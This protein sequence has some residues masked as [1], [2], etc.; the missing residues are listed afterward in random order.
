M[1]VFSCINTERKINALQSFLNT[2]EHY[3]QEEI[4]D[5]FL[6]QFGEGRSFMYGIENDFGIVV[7]DVITEISE[8]MDKIFSVGFFLCFACCLAFA[9]YAFSDE[10]QK[11]GGSFI[12]ALPYGKSYVLA[13][14]WLAGFA[15]I[16]LCMAVSFA[17]TMGFSFIFLDKAVQCQRLLGTTQNLY[18]AEKL[19]RYILAFTA[20][21]AFYSVV[22]FVFTLF[23][24]VYQAL[25]LSI[26]GV[27]AALC[28]MEGVTSFYDIYDI[29]FARDFLM[30]I[31]DVIVDL[32]VFGCTIVCI[33]AT[34]VFFALGALTN[35]LNRVENNGK[36]FMFKPVKYLAYAAFMLM[37]AFTFFE[38][39][40]SAGGMYYAIK[41]SMALGLCMLLVGAAATLWVLNKL[42]EKIG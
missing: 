41:G 34:F 33:I 32:D 38:L 2:N 26:A 5:K 17:C 15:V 29:V 7:P 37:G 25:A 13:S 22:M 4:N 16:L 9:V 36:M 39:I 35:R 12:N 14:K 24:K 11:S 42:L 27:I 30:K 40:H 18:F 10:R 20:I 31:V 6:N 21:C 1:L 8:Q 19:S 28:A 3:T 23:G